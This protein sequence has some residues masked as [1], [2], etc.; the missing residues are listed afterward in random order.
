MDRIRKSVSLDRS[1][2]RPFREG[3][4]NEQLWKYMKTLWEDP[5]DYKVLMAR[6]MLNLND[7]LMQEWDVKGDEQYLTD[8]IMSNTAFLLSAKTIADRYSFR[9]KFPRILICDD[10]MLHGRGVLKLIDNFIKI[11]SRRL[12]E[13]SIQVDEKQL[14]EN[15]YRS[16]SIYIFARNS[17]EGLLIDENRYSLYSAKILPINDLRK[18]S[19]QISDYLQ[20]RGTPNT[21]YVL[22]VRIT[23]E[24]IRRLLSE[25]AS[26]NAQSFQYQGRKQMIYFRDRSPRI[27]ETVR[28]YF[29]DIESEYGGVL[30]SLAVFGD[31]SGDVFD[32]LCL[33]MAHFMEQNVRYSQIATYLR[34]K[35]PELIKP[36]AQLLSFLYSILSITDFCRQY[37]DAEGNDLYRILVSGDFNKII[38]NFD[39]GDAFRYEILSFFRAVCMDR[40]TAAVLWDYLEYAAQDL[41]FNQRISPTY[42]SGLF[43]CISGPAT[44]DRL[45]AYEDAEDIFYE[46]G[47]D[48]EY[49]AYRYYRTGTPFDADR[50]G[51]DLMTFRQY[52]Q[53][54][55]RNKNTWEHSV[56]CTFGLMDSGL[57]SLNMETTVESVRKTVRT[58][59]KAGELSTYV[60]PRR[61]SIFIPALAVVESQYKKV[62]RYVRD[63]IGSFVDYLQD[64]YYTS[65]GQTDPRDIQLLKTLEKKKVLLLYIY[66]AGQSFRDWDIELKNERMYRTDRSAIQEE[67]FT[68]E[69]EMVRKNHYSRLARQFINQYAHANN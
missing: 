60:L 62:G 42:R 48:A 27:L 35:D 49:D 25:G 32:T 53:I 65:G 59:L 24:Q 6:R 46:V 1:Y 47:M 18:L 54:M 12:N 69:E 68:L 21:S 20:R 61:F 9:K 67:A 7:A 64:N 36:R 2:N 40:S 26:E 14:K 52:M 38:S 16:I 39:K 5:A 56:G 8:R 51:F 22:S 15:L 34:M 30:T 58:V 31:I 43:R 10:I 33:S 17:D 41:V 45:K 4:Y 50:S 23:R 3:N 66:S 57:I 11:V 44:D 19:L 55:Q 37:L 63:V 13:N 29:P 28:L